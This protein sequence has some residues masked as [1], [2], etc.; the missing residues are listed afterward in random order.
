MKTLAFVTEGRQVAFI[1]V[2]SVAMNDMNEC[3]FYLCMCICVCHHR[4]KDNS[5]IMS[6]SEIHIMCSGITI[7]KYR[8][9]F[10][11]VVNKTYHNLLCKHSIK[12]IC[13]NQIP[14]A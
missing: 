14:S 1:T 2:E 7:H 11:Y 10:C 9:G 5:S 4:H 12:I 8:Y 6:V 3:L 13:I